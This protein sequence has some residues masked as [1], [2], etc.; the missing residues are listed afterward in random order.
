MS[1]RIARYVPTTS[2]LFP[3]AASIQLPLTRDWSLNKEGFLSFVYQPLVHSTLMCRNLTSKGRLG[4]ILMIFRDNVDYFRDNV[5]VE[6]KRRNRRGESL[7][8]LEI[9]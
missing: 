4:A 7:L 8:E 2:N 5:R 1:G 6:G 9:R 3:D